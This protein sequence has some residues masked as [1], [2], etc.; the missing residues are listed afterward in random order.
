VV[1]DDVMRAL[2]HIEAHLEQDLSAP[3]LAG[4][5]GLSTSRFH[6]VFAAEVSET[7]HAY[8]TRVRLDRA[9]FY[10]ATLQGTISDVAVTVGYPTP[11]TF[12]RAFFRRFATSPAGY[13]AAAPVRARTPV[14]RPG[15]EQDGVSPALSAVRAVEL[16]AQP[17]AFVRHVGPYED[18]DGSLFD[19][20]AAWSR[21]R[22]GVTGPWL[23]IGHDAPGITP[24][25]LLRFDACLG[26]TAQ[27][28]SR[29]RVAFQTAPGGWYA[30]A[31]YTGPFAAL[32]E[33][34][35]L[36]YTTALTFAGF[37]VAG[38]PLI[39]CYLTSTVRPDAHLNTTQIRLPLARLAALPGR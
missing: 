3:A 7:P 17:V 27:H 21:G 31:T 1:R 22:S 25:R 26:V 29:G 4:V 11:E 35:R 20:V 6:R 24:A 38:L 30:V 37:R 28:H 8:V 39:E 12:S 36:V 14:R 19:E 9:A 18:V 16:R 32:P 23:G 10:L 33:A 2:V 5:A 34:H 13:R 15:L